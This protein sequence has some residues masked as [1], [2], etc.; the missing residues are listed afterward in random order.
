[1]K[2]VADL[3]YRQ[4]DEGDHHQ[5]VAAE[6]VGNLEGKIEERPRQYIDADH[7]QHHDQCRNASELAGPFDNAF[8]EPWRSRTAMCAALLDLYHY[9]GWDLSPQ[10]APYLRQRLDDVG[11]ARLGPFVPVRCHCL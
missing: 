3:A 5:H 4:A 6:L 9:D 10:R 2:A 8:L 7:D 11:P 1:M